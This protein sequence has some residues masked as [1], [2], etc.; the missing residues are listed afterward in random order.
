MGKDLV[1]MDRLARDT[2]AEADEVLG[3]ALSRM[4]FEGP[5]DELRQ[6]RNTQPAILVH[7][8]AVCR[9]L[10]AAG[11]TPG[12]VAG[13]SVG[14]YSALVAAGVMS[15]PDA[16]R[17][18]R[19]RGELM[20]EAGIRRPGTM[21]AI[22]GLEDEVVA[23]ICRQATS[24][25]V[26]VRPANFNAPQQVVISGDV[27]AVD[28]AVALAKEQK[29]KRAVRLEVS[30]AFHSP[31]ME[32][33]AAGLAEVLAEVPL[34]APAVPVVSNVTAELEQRPEE[35]RRLLMQQLTSPVLW[36]KSLETMLREGFTRA[37]ECGPGTVLRGLWKRVAVNGAGFGVQDRKTLE[38][39]LADVTS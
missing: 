28:R 14:E 25:D 8:V 27:S 10:A 2:F 20:Y 33:A 18:V 36:A 37:V 17:A 29:A 5:E 30:G 7:S 35:I 15:Y 16:L 6:T 11:I 13:H 9:V 26:V 31:L 3:T 4:C 21:A 19:R 1:E 24:P 32:Y 22:I 39:F 38:E 12:V 23:D 34:E